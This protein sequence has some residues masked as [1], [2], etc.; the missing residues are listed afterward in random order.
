MPNID[1][2][3]YDAG[4]K[5]LLF[6]GD[7]EK[8]VNTYIDDLKLDIQSA[9]YDKTIENGIAPKIKR[10]KELKKESDVRKMA[11]GVKALYEEIREIVIEPL[12]IRR[13]RIDLLEMRNTKR[14]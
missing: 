4:N 8:S 9:K 5:G 3:V 1:A 10:Y 11:A 13:T 14:I 2:L 6:T 7:E 12:T